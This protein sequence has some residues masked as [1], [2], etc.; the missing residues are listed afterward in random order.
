MIEWKA[1]WKILGGDDIA[2]RFYRRYA[3]FLNPDGSCTGPFKVGLVGFHIHRVTANGHIGGTFEQV[4]NTRLQRAYSSAA[5][6]GAAGLPDHASLNPGGRTSPD[7][8]NGYEVC[9]S[10]GN[11]CVSGVGGIVPK[12]IQD[13]DVLPADPQISNIIRQIP[14]PADVQ[15][16]NAAWRKKLK[17]SVWFYYQMIG[18]QNANVDEPNPN[19]GPGVRGA[20]VSNTNNLINTTLESYT[21]AGWNCAQCHLNAFPLGVTLPLPPF[22]DA[23]EPLHLIS[24]LLQ[25][26]RSSSGTGQ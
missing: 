22:E 16:R 25:T 20:Q 17:G 18:T 3:F 13:G 8:P 11:N 12:P 24:F 21:Q 15:K 5:V 10:A 6:A 23:Y 1:A 26:A 7:S 19:L 4:D 9:D 2:E 14:I